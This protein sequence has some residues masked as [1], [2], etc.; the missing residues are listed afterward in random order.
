MPTG[1]EIAALALPLPVVGGVATLHEG[2]A[3]FGNPE[4]FIAKLLQE[5]AL[6]ESIYQSIHH[7]VGETAR[8]G[9]AAR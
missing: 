6:P 1:Q 7:A 5:A 9:N 3:R 8:A 4:Q 2:G